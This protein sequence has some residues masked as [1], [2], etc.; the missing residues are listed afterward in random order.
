MSFPKQGN[1]KTVWTAW[2]I[3]LQGRQIND[4]W[5]CHQKP[6]GGSHFL[7]GIGFGN[8]KDGALQKND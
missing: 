6:Y 3:R 2:L 8:G 1:T 4:T 5:S 7:R